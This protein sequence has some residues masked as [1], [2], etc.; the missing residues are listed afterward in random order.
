MTSVSQEIVSMFFSL[1]PIHLPSTLPLQALDIPYPGSPDTI[2]SQE[3]GRKSLLFS[4]QDLAGVLFFSQGQPGNSLNQ[5]GDRK[6]WVA[7]QDHFPLRKIR[8]KWA[9]G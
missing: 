2:W 3:L 7:A 1:N 8:L 6:A 9:T 5:S 4:S